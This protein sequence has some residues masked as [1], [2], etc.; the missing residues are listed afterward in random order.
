MIYVVV[1]KAKPMRAGV[2]VTDDDV[3]IL[4]ERHDLFV[5]DSVEIPAK[6]GLMQIGGPLINWQTGKIMLPI[7]TKVAMQRVE[8]YL[9]TLV[10]F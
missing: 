2:I 4:K 7:I 1:G 6:A 3:A 5:V 10:K 9:S 8:M